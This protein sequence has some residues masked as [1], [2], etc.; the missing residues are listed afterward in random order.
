MLRLLNP[1]YGYVFKLGQRT[2][3]DGS[4]AANTS[5]AVGAGE[6]ETPAQPAGFALMTITLMD[7]ISMTD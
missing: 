4:I 3:C 1:G 7:L 5:Q 2:R 6:T